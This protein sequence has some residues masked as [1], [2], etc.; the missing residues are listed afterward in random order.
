MKT[1]GGQTR[2]G[3]ELVDTSIFN[4]NRYFDAVEYAK[5]RLTHP[6]PY[7]ANRKRN[8]ALHLLPNIWF[9]TTGRGARKER[10]LSTQHCLGGAGSSFAQ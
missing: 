3:F 10:S 2:S 6:N 7:P 4:E 1:A 5:E 9:L 8:A